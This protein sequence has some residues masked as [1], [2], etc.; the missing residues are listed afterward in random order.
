MSS[1]RIAFASVSDRPKDVPNPV[2]ASAAAD[3][4]R[5][6]CTGSIF[7]AMP[8]TV[9]KRVWNSVVTVVAVITSPSEM[10]SAA[11]FRG[12]V[13]AN[14]L[15]PKIVEATTSAPTFTGMTGR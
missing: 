2:N 7:S 6:S 3:R 1:V 5:L 4:V 10:R 8:E 12:A 9:S 13:K 14:I 11:G 15:L